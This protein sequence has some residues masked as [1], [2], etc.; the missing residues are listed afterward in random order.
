MRGIWYD[1]RYFAACIIRWSTL[2]WTVPCY[3]IAC[4]WAN[5]HPTSIG[6][7][8]LPSDAAVV[9]GMCRRWNLIMRQLDIAA[10]QGPEALA[11][12]RSELASDIIQ[13]AWVCSA[14]RFL[15]FLKRIEGNRPR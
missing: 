14:L 15:C 7:G 3:R 6:R 5:I 8:H 2:W 13:W 9:E 4:G 1:M 11:R 12:R 10:E